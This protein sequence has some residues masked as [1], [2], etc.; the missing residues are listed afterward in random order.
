M[1]DNIGGKLKGLAKAIFAVEAIISGIGGL[2]IIANSGNL[3]VLGFLLMIVG[4]LVSWIS[5]WF[6]YGFGEL[7]ES[8]REIAQNTRTNPFRSQFVP[9]KADSCQQNFAPHTDVTPQESGNAQPVHSDDDKRI[10]ELINLRS[11]GL[12]TE[13][14]FEHAIGKR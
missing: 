4:F 7:I 8:N 9:H 13:A 11:Q 14:E 3:A 5:S 6:L 12:I 1:Y 10:Q 2:V